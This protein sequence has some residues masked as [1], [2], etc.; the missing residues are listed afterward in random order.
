ME[1][2]L[3]DSGRR[4]ESAVSE[5]MTGLRCSVITSLEDTAPSAS[6]MALQK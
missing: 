4:R 5:N 1:S 3:K 6:S 2:P